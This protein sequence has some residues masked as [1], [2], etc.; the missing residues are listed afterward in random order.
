M[1]SKNSDLHSSDEYWDSFIDGRGITMARGSGSSRKSFGVSSIALRLAEY[2]EVAG[3][4]IDLAEFLT[5][6]VSILAKLGR[7]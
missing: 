3:N 5:F 7:R 4:A 2:S 6:R 1:L